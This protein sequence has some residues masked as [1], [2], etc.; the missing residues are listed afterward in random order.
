MKYLAILLLMGNIYASSKEYNNKSSSADD[1]KRAEIMKE[2]NE[3]MED[4][5]SP[6]DGQRC[7]EDKE[8][9]LQELRY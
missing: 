3:C 9:A 2:Y 7:E 1:E 4:V 8:R 6:E 5:R